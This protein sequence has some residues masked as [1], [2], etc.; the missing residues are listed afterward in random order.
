MLHLNTQWKP[1]NF[2]VSSLNVSNRA[3]FCI[4]MMYFFPQLMLKYVYFF[5]KSRGVGVGGARVMIKG[6]SGEGKK[7]NTKNKINYN[8]VNLLLPTLGRP[9]I[10]T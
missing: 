1:S 5:K 6:R 2:I 3:H 4:K 7:K 8:E 10:V 9:V